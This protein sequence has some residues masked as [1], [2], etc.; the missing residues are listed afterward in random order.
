MAQRLVFLWTSVYL[1]VCES[2]DAVSLCRQV[3][4]LTH[5]RAEMFESSDKHTLFPVRTS[6]LCCSSLLS[7]F[8]ATIEINLIIIHRF[9]HQSAAALCVREKQEMMS[10]EEFRLNTPSCTISLTFLSLSG[11]RLRQDSPHTL[12]HTHSCSCQ[13]KN[14]T[15]ESLP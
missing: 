10:Q 2:A 4:S 15:R 11:F 14:N 12:T 1:K 7:L 3:G 8:I 9:T 5:T 13:I 6:L